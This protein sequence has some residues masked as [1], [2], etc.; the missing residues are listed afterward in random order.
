MNSRANLG[1][2]AVNGIGQVKSVVKRFDSDPSRVP[3]TRELLKAVQRS[4]KTYSERLKASTVC[5]P[6]TEKKIK[7]GEKKLCL[8]KCL[9]SS[10]A[11]LYFPALPG[12]PHQRSQ[13][14]RRR[15]GSLE[16]SSAAALPHRGHRP[17]QA[18]VLKARRHRILQHGRVPATSSRR[19]PRRKRLP[20]RVKRPAFRRWLA[21]KALIFASLAADCE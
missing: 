8:E 20:Q 3:L 19:T 11:M 5:E 6:V 10:K 15:R 16:R 9:E 14:L 2:A 18:Q 13:G 4:H 17:R 21:L 7:L 12:R 1:I